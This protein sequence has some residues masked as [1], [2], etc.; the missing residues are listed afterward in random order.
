MMK[1][2]LT[3]LF[4]LL[5]SCA[6][7]V[8]Q[9]C[10]NISI[11][12]MREIPAESINARSCYTL[13]GD[14]VYKYDNLLCQRAPCFGLYE[15]DSEG[16]R[17]DSFIYLSD[18]LESGVFPNW[19]DTSKHVITRVTGFYYPNREPSTTPLNPNSQEVFFATDIE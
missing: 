9:E 8:F 11:Q 1:L 3:L 14:L 18:S 12:D 19:S 2:F 4:F 17:I 13:F 16:N 6:E 7:D 15:V 5:S 10:K